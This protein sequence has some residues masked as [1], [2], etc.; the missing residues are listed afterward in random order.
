[1]NIPVDDDRCKVCTHCMMLS[2]RMIG[3]M[4]HESTVPL[5]HDRAPGFFSSLWWMM[6]TIAIFK[7]SGG[8]S[9][10][11]DNNICNIYVLSCI[12]FLMHIFADIITMF[13]MFADMGIAL[14][15]YIHKIA[16][17]W[18]TNDS[19]LG[20]FR[21]VTHWLSAYPLYISN[22]HALRWTTP[23]LFTDTPIRAQCHFLSTQHTFLPEKKKDAQKRNDG[24]RK[25]QKP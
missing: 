4:G 23:P 18:C 14:G 21:S 8:P 20:F 13:W 11:T 5:V 3:C 7:F 25:L 9:A 12:G 22:W 1:M 15:L 19:W 24:W 2:H 6:A 16:F 17:Q 10:L